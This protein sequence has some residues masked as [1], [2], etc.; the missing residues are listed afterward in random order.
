MILCLILAKKMPRKQYK[1]SFKLKVI[2]RAKLTSKNL[3]LN[4][5]FLVNVLFD[6]VSQS[7]SL[8][9]QN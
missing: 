1:I 4:L 5:E 9:N 6:G 2:L 7:N 8:K 3:R